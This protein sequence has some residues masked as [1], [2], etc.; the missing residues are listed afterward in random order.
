[1]KKGILVFL[2][3]LIAITGKAQDSLKLSFEEY[4]EW[5]R[6]YHPIAVQAEINLRMGQMEVRQ[7]RGGFDPLVYG[8]LDK[9][10]YKESNYYDK[11]E[12]GVVVP[13][14]MGVELNGVFEQNTG[15]F[16]N[17]ESNVPTTGLLSAGASVN[18]GQGLI[19]D[20]RRATLRKAQIYQQATEVERQ[21][22][23]NELNL[24]AT[25]MY[26]RWS[27]A[28][29]NV[30][31]LREGVELAKF[32]FNAVKRFFELGDQ[33]AIDT[34]E[35]FTQLLN[36]EYRLQIA[37]NTFFAAT[38][39]LNTYLWDEDGNPMVLENGVVPQGLFEEFT[40]APDAEELRTLV[41]RHPELRLTDYEL[42]SLDVERRLKTQQLLPVVKL[43]Y[44]FLSESLSEFNTSPFFENNYKWGV[45]FYTPLLLRKT[46]GAL[47]LTKAKIEMKQTSRDLKELQLRTKLESELYNWSILNQQVST[48]SQNVKS[49]EALLTGESRRFEIG[50]STLFLVNAREVAVFDSRLTLNDLASKLRTSYA[51]TRFAAGLGFEEN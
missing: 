18:L 28:K 43:K 26:W 36:R 14:W 47:G 19:L 5:V 30:E 23:L 7:A 42:A 32:R 11:R 3:S 24:Q 41:A 10:E 21:N 8:N 12:A 17:S 15:R 27:L 44:N 20:D 35:A 1:M 38:Q 40:L 29:E 31:V 48:I 13:T 37:E 6:L 33:A 25:D 22:M 16:L 9:K 39:E 50:E 2:F 49:L 46:R 4:M 45:S 51:K 34:V